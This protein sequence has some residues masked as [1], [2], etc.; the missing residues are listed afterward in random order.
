MPKEK[1]VTQEKEETKKDEMKKE[2]TKR[3]N[4]SKKETNK[5]IEEVIER[6][7]EIERN[8]QK[9]ETNKKQTKTTTSKANQTKKESTKKNETKKKEENKLNEAKPQEKKK[10]KKGSKKEVVVKENPEELDK[11]KLEKIEEEI[12]KQTT[13]PDEKKKKI[14]KRIFQNIMVAIVIVLYFIFINLGFYNIEQAKFLVDLQVFSMVSIAITIIIFEVAY[15]KD[16]GELAIYGIESL[17]LSICTLLT[18]N[19]GINYRNKF[20]YII[21][22]ISMLFAIYYVVKSIIIYIK[23]KRKALKRASDIDKIRRVK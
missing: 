17:V 13:I 16:S 4:T 7:E 15:K 14:N 22:T 19:L 12:K 8:N 18:I 5:R 21:N 2:T 9:K 1:A 6:V 20:S 11:E 3:K 10:T 23:M